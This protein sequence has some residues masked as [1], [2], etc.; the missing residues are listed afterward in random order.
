MKEKAAKK[1][2]KRKLPAALKKYQFKK[3]HAPQKKGSRRKP[4]KA[5]KAA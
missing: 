5:R 1:K 2:P 3:G 4:A